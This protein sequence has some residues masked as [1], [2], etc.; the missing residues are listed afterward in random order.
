MDVVCSLV[1]M[2]G[3]YPPSSGST[4]WFLLLKLMLVFYYYFI[5]AKASLTCI[6][7]SFAK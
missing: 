2:E 1:G 6:I 5:F 3:S 7:F 4:F